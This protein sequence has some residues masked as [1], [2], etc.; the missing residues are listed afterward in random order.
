MFSSTRQETALTDLDWNSLLLGLPLSAAARGPLCRAMLLWDPT[1]DQLSSS[2]VRTA[3]WYGEACGSVWFLKVK[4]SS[5]LYVS[6][7]DYILKLICAYC[8]KKSWRI[9]LKSKWLS[10]L[11]HCL[12]C[13]VPC[14]YMHESHVGFTFVFISYCRCDKLP[15]IR[16]LKT[17]QTHYLIVLEVGSLNM[18]VMNWILSSPSPPNPQFIRWSLSGSN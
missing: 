10:V 5:S 2:P 3:W 17:I 7:H 1:E 14:T 6:E 15:Q 16:R 8:R 9:M 11:I 12:P 4:A 13:F 18:S